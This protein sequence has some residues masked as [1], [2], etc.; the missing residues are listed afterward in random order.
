VKITRDSHC[1][2]NLVLNILGRREDGFHEL[3][4][5]FWPVRL[6]D[7]LEF[8]A[9][10]GH[11]EL[12]C[13]HPELPVDGG[14]LVHKAATAFYGKLGRAPAARIHLEKRLPIAAGIGAGSANAAATLLGLN[15][16]L[17]KPLGDGDLSALAAG[18]G[19]DVPCFLGDAPALGVGRGEMVTPVEG[20]PE[21]KEA[22][23]VLYHPGFGVS[24]PWAYKNL[25]R[26]PNEL[27]GAPGRVA[28][29]VD[30]LR[31]GEVREIQRHLFN[32]LEAPVLD[33]HPILR[34]YQEFFA[35]QG[36][37]GTLMSGSGSTTFAVFESGELAE[38]A[39]ARFRE[40]FGPS[41]WLACAEF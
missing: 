41:G 19:S 28:R 18:I 26:F 37:A 36:A 31:G 33:K 22:R 34:I 24:T 1:K 9:T 27:N 8:S 32:S 12:T 6:Y 30:F 38:G 7:T 39:M 20:L 15:E 4:T 21:F 2:V 14:N 3:E 16:L 40:A 10:S 5:L 23:M 35:E 25:A 29:M 17:G 11:L 13:S